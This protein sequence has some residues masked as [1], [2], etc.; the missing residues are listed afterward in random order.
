MRACFVQTCFKVDCEGD[1]YPYLVR[2][3]AELC[4]YFFRESNFYEGHVRENFLWVSKVYT[5]P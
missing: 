4:A 3:E 5:F 2:L 1:V